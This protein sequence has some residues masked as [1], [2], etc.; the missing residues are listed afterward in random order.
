[1]KPFLSKKYL[2]PVLLCLNIL[3]ISGLIL[4]N[5]L[6]ARNSIHAVLDTSEEVLPSLKNAGNVQVGSKSYIIYD[7]SSRAV[8]AGK[9]ENLRFAPASTA[10][11]MAATIVI[12]NYSLD[13]VLTATNLKALGPDN[14]RMG[15]V[16]GE[17]MTV[18]NL[19]YG[20]MLPSGNDAAYVLAENYPGGI[21]S[22][23][24]KMNDKAKELDLINTKFFDP[25]GYDDNNYTTA[26]DLARL[27]A[28]AIKNP[29]FAQIVSTKN[30]TVYDITG[31]IDHRLN[32][33]NELLGRKGVSGIKTGFTDEAGEV[34]VTSI[35]QRER[36]YIISVLNSPDRFGDTTKIINGAVNKIRL[37]TY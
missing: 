25:D 20:M 7:T 3:L 6:I 10:K 22:F 33:L 4:L 34:L 1:M 2:L 15:L 31:K 8:I 19:L 23:V 9:N 37:L 28:Y 35:N 21:S 11:I 29:V 14:S 13:R 30:K 17:S 26:Y 16:D 36:T 12:E 18:R 5:S 32:N 27:G 24:S